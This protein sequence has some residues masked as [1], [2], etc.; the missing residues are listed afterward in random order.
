MRVSSVTFVFTYLVAIFLVGAILMPSSKLMLSESS[1]HPATNY[2][3]YL[4][5]LNYF[6]S[7]KQTQFLDLQFHF[8]SLATFLRRRVLRKEI[9]NYKR[10]DFFLD[11][12]RTW[13]CFVICVN[14]PELSN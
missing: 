2:N 4:Q 1:V 7:S 10:Q 12:T 14:Q 11:I 13:N 9:I 6:H 5:N 3:A 8:L